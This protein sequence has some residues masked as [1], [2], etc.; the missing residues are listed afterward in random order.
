MVN[1][2][3]QWLRPNGRRSAEE[4]ADVWCDLFLARPA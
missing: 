4:I 3:P 1:Y 2:A